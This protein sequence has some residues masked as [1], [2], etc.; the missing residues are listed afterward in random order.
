MA[1]PAASSRDVLMRLPVDNCCM[2]T[3]WF[4]SVAFKAACENSA[5]TLV[6]ITA[7]LFS[8]DLLQSIFHR[9]LCKSCAISTNFLCMH[10]DD[11]CFSLKRGFQNI[12]VQNL[13]PRQLKS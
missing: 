11:F 3:C 12:T 4:R 2:D 5:L 9:W 10:L 7:I 13:F 6:L 1:I 8:P